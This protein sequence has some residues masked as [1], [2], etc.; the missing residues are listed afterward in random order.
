MIPHCTSVFP[1]AMKKIGLGKFWTWLTRGNRPVFPLSVWLFGG[2]MVNSILATLAYV[3]M[4][5]AISWKGVWLMEL[6]PSA[7]TALIPFAL[8]ALGG[9]YEGLRAETT[10]NQWDHLIAFIMLD[11]GL[12]LHIPYYLRLI[13]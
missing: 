12:A 5:G 9:I 3:K 13:A 4:F 6:L 1:T 2:F 7:V 11:A 10:F 8:I